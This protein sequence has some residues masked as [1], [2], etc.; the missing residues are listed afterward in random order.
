MTVKELTDKGIVIDRDEM[1]QGFTLARI[2]NDNHLEMQF[3]R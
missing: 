1:V 3:K 2:L